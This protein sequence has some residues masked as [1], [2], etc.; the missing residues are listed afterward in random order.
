MIRSQAPPA[1]NDVSEDTKTL[2]LWGDQQGRLSPQEQNRALG[3]GAW[4]RLAKT[5]RQPTPE[6]GQFL[7]QILLESPDD[8]LL[9]IALGT[10]ANHGNRQNLARGYLERARQ[11]PA[12]EEAAV[13]DGEARGGRF[14]A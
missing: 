12:V 4:A 6:L 14:L 11:I 7:G 2:T 9:L 8:G 13:A 3:L 5:G 1:N 10:M